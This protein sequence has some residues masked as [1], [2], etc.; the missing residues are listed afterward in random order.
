[1]MLAA[2]VSNARSSLRAFGLLPWALIT[3]AITPVFGYEHVTVLLQPDK[4]LAV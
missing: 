1:M 4:K 2:Q 3:G